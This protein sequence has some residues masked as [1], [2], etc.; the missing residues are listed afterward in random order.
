MFWDDEKQTV[1][2]SSN[3]DEERNG[4]G[5]KQQ[6]EGDSDDVPLAE[7]LR[8]EG[9]PAG[10]RPAEGETEEEDEEVPEE[11]LEELDKSHRAEWKGE[12]LRIMPEI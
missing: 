4:G 5:E 10:T 9:E 1:E 6:Q 2:D 11:E 3:E 8:Q 7:L 12:R